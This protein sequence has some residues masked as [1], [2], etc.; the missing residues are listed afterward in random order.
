MVT[1]SRMHH[2]SSLF[3]D[4]H[5]MIILILDVK[6][7][8]LRFNLTVASLLKGKLDG[9][10]ISWSYLIVGLYWHFIY[11][12]VIGISCILYPIA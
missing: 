4:D 2:Q 12:D 8:I 11:E 9:N 3:I 7:D 5:N 1:Y 10:D 6:G